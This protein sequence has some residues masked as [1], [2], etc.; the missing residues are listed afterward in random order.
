MRQ[1]LG[2][3]ERLAGEVVPGGRRERDRLLSRLRAQASSV[4][5]V[6]EPTVVAV[7]RCVTIDVDGGPAQ[8]FW[9]ALP[10]D[11]N[12][13]AATIS[14]ASPMGQAVAGAHVGDHVHLV[15]R[16]LP[17]CGVVRSVA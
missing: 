8:T 3:L 16:A 15:D 5:V 11:E 7:G 14:I 13:T 10:G 6:F 4:R 9:L 17:A 2:R 1:L 12:A